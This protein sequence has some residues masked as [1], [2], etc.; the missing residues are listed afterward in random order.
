MS[1]SYIN[2]CEHERKIKAIFKLASGIV[3]VNGLKQVGLW[4][5]TE[6]GRNV[7]GQIC[8]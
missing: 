4:Q 5:A 3:L 6:A 8:L 2:A 7:T 1:G